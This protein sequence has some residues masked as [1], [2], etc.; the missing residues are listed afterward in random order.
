MKT[1]HQ[2]FENTAEKFADRIAIEY[3]PTVGQEPQRYTYKQLNEDTNRF[4]RY[5]ENEFRVTQ[6]D[7][8]AV[9]L[10]RSPEAI[11]AILAIMKLGATYAPLPLINDK[12][13]YYQ[14]NV[15]R[16]ELSKQL[17]ELKPKLILSNQELERHLSP[18]MKTGNLVIID[19]KNVR[20]AY[21]KIE[22][23]SN[24]N[25]PPATWA[26]IVATSGTTGGPKLI[27][28][29]PDALLNRCIAHWQVTKLM[30]DDRV[31]HIFQL[32]KDPSLMEIMMALGKGACLCPIPINTFEDTLLQFYEK[33]Q[34]TAGIFLPRVVDSWL[35]RN[36]RIKKIIVMGDKPDPNLFRELLTHKN[37][38]EILITGYGVS[39]ATIA[40]TLCR[41]DLIDLPHIYLGD[42]IPGVILRVYQRTDD[43]KHADVQKLLYEIGGEIENVKPKY[44]IDQESTGELYL[45][46]HHGGVG[47]YLNS[48]QLNKEKFICLDGKRFYKTEDKVTVF[49]G[50]GLVFIGRFSA[51]K[52][53]SGLWIY[54]E[55]VE[56]EIK[57]VYKEKF[58][59]NEIPRI[60]TGVT[61]TR[62][63]LAVLVFENKD[64]MISKGQCLFLRQELLKRL[65]RHMMPVYWKFEFASQLT[66][67]E[68][69]NKILRGDICGFLLP[70]A[71]APHYQNISETEQELLEIWGNILGIDSHQLNIN[72][73]FFDELGGSS[74]DAYQLIKKLSDKY[75]FS[76]NITEF[77]LHQT[78]TYLARQIAPHY[79][80]PQEEKLFRISESKEFSDKLPLFLIHAGDGD[81]SCYYPLKGIIKNRAIY[82]IGAKS[83]SWDIR[84]MDVTVEEIAKRYAQLIA[85]TL[86]PYKECII[87]GYSAGGIIANEL[88]Y[89]LKTQYNIKASVLLFDSDSPSYW[90]TISNKDYNTR[91]KEFAELILRLA[92]KGEESIPE[93]ILTIVNK[94][95]ENPPLVQ[96]NKIISEISETFSSHLLWKNSLL[97]ALII[98]RAI[99]TT[100]QPNFEV[101]TERFSSEDTYL[102][103]ASDSSRNKER[104]LGWWK[105]SRDHI[106]P[107][108]E[109]LSND[110]SSERSVTHLNMLTHSEFHNKL[111]ELL[112]TLDNLSTI[113]FI[114]KN[115]FF[116]PML[117]AR[118][119]FFLDFGNLVDSYV[120]KEQYQGI[121]KILS[122]KEHTLPEFYKSIYDQLKMIPK[123][124]EFY[125]SRNINNFRFGIVKLKL[126]I[127]GLSDIKELDQ[128]HLRIYKLL[129]LLAI[130]NLNALLYRSLR[131]NKEA[132]INFTQC[133]YFIQELEKQ[134]KTKSKE[135]LDQML[136]PTKFKYNIG[137]IY[138]NL[139]HLIEELAVDSK[140]NH[141]IN[142][143]KF[144]D[145][146]ILACKELGIPPLDPANYR[147]FC[148]FGNRYHEHAI[149]YRG[150]D[151]GTLN[152]KAVALSAYCNYLSN[153]ITELDKIPLHQVSI[154]FY[155]PRIVAL[156]KEADKIFEEMR[157]LI[158]KKG[159]SE[160][161]MPLRLLL[162]HARLH[163]AI[164]KYEESLLIYKKIYEITHPKNNSPAITQDISSE[165]SRQIINEI[166]EVY[167]LCGKQAKD[168]EL[169][170]DLLDKAQ[171][172]IKEYLQEQEKYNSELMKNVVADNSD[173]KEPLECLSLPFGDYKK[174]LKL[175]ETILKEAEVR[176]S[177]S[178]GAK[179]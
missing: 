28:N 155:Q 63:I 37:H 70:S 99:S 124:I 34:I 105:L 26:Y 137:T 42:P 100:Y 144:I 59:D 141:K 12:D 166:G 82:A 168:E 51:F 101:D 177:Y 94:N 84:Y 40:N 32:N 15:Q 80:N 127:D 145:S 102:F 115:L 60:I 85:K 149:Y 69:K 25:K 143:E 89:I 114:K 56:N 27:K 10:T 160:G 7:I 67:K 151:V 110:K 54:F 96:I 39:E 48:E 16:I 46:D 88:R 103:A 120:S 29:R 140:I 134:L 31:A 104:N 61:P 36:Y 58:P 165:L 4:A 62:K 55:S 74:I 65:Q 78:I 87:G 156:Y 152:G 33:L 92:V 170:K 45:S 175:L 2:Y 163:K 8:I 136:V 159:G 125:H 113:K 23:V 73:R 153:K 19:S 90:Q 21:S 148:D 50:K 128:S 53:T 38:P 162:N 106:L 30:E 41:I 123:I 167:Y 171:E 49:P 142:R 135:D 24:L 111:V 133:W 17:S 150:K 13:R 47:E 9:Y 117:E 116:L 14:A 86:Q 174:A 109:D 52:N 164:H 132:L 129:A 147:L 5:L 3:F 35:V 172:K 112:Q 98:A 146:Y 161:N 118:S 71:I 93:S 43:D 122:S 179:L 97:V 154:K 22:D 18:L 57:K 83:A 44:H 157:A 79:D 108:G 1:F 66:N 176:I 131:M 130:H 126:V 76:L 169:K 91:L 20:Y 107:I 173:I 81:I 119:L 139:G 158:I 75:R 77:Y 95:A 138:S 6:N 64:K 178:I 11:I 72:Y 68:I 121:L